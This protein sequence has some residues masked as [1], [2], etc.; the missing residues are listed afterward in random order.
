MRLWISIIMIMLTLTFWLINVI[1]F[2]KM[3][4]KNLVMLSL[5]LTAIIVIELTV[6]LGIIMNL[7]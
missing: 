1:R 6:S 7:R 5:L 4:L 3:L 2:C